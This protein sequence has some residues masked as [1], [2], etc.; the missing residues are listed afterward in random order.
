MWSAGIILYQMLFGRKPFGHG[1]TPET[2]LSQ[3]TISRATTVEFPAKPAIPDI[4]K[5][6]IRRCLAH[7]P[8]DRPDLLH[9]FS[10]P[11]LKLGRK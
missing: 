6:F 2:M 3:Q 4:T 9:V 10:E 11:Y 8:N 7:N 5:D 1:L